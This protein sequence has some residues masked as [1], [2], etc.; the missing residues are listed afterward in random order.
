MTRGPWRRV[1]A[2]AFVII[3][4]PSHV[5]AQRVIPSERASVLLPAVRT[6][7]FFARDPGA[8]LALGLIASPA[9]NVR[10]QLDVG[11][12]GVARTSGWASA[13]RA[14]LLL[15][16]V[17]DPFRRARWALHAG[18]GVGVAVESSRALRPLGIVTLGVEG[19]AKGRWLPGVE[20]G[21]GGGV[22]AGLTMRR[23]RPGR[24]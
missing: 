15:R 4:G 13:G 20:L 1:V 21:L 22:R 19:P 7:L 14:E 16:W 5:V 23:V 11:A 17:S 8:Q 12:G 9:Y 24:R 10:V 6:D 2:V 18:G 3:C